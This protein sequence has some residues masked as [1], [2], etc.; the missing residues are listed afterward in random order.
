MAASEGAQAAIQAL[1]R[2]EL[3]THVL[4]E[5]EA[6]PD[7]PRAGASSGG[8]SPR[9]AYSCLYWPDARADRMNLLPI[10][11]DPRHIDEAPLSIS[12]TRKYKITATTTLLNLAIFPMNCVRSHPRSG[13]GQNQVGNVSEPQVKARWKFRLR[14]GS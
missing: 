9:R 1:H 8:R 13:P 7:E 10:H 5:S 12:Q 4:T 6:Q 11:D 3:G 14:T 2:K